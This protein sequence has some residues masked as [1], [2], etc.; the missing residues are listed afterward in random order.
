MARRI[1]E[2][3][4]EDKTPGQVRSDLNRLRNALREVDSIIRRDLD[5][6]ARAAIGGALRKLDPGAELDSLARSAS[7]FARACEAGGR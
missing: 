4:D 5:D 1:E 6:G 3:Q 2:Q 7:L